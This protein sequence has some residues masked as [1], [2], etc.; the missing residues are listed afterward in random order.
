MGQSIDRQGTEIFVSGIAI[1]RFRNKKGEENRTEDTT[2]TRGDN[3]EKQRQKEKDKKKK[4][5]H[6]HGSTINLLS[7][8]GAITNLILIMTAQNFIETKQ[9][10]YY[11][12]PSL[13]VP[14]LF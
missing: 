7:N 5:K 13:Y 9:E 2:E 10:K 8:D 14:T 1:A 6:V 11:I 4:K 3:V 12:F